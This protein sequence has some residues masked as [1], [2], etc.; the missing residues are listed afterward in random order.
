M[1]TALNLRVTYVAAD[2]TLIATVMEGYV[3][4]KEYTANVFATM[5]VTSPELQGSISTSG[6]SCDTAFPCWNH[7]NSFYVGE[8]VVGNVTQASLGF[9]LWYRDSTQSP[10]N[11]GSVFFA[12]S[13][14]MELLDVTGWF[15][16]SSHPSAISSLKRPC[17]APAR[18]MVQQDVGYSRRLS[19][20][21][22]T[23]PEEQ[24]LHVSIA[25]LRSHV[26][27]TAAQLS[28]YN[29]L[30]FEPLI[31]DLTS[32]EH[33]TIFASMDS[34]SAV[35]QE[36]TNQI[37][38]NDPG[39]PA[40]LVQLTTSLK[41]FALAISTP[42]IVYSTNRQHAKQLI[43]QLIQKKAD[44]A[45][46]VKQ[47]QHEF[48]DL[49]LDAYLK[50][51]VSSLRLFP[52]LIEDIIGHTR[53]TAPEKVD[54]VECRQD[55][56]KLIDRVH[57]EAKKMD[58]LAQLTHYEQLLLP[59]GDATKLPFNL[60]MPGRSFVQERQASINFA[61]RTLLRGKKQSKPIDA[62]LIL[63][64]DMLL[65]T[66][67]TKDSGTSK[68]SVISHKG[69][70]LFLT[71][72]KVDTVTQSPTV[73][74]A[75]KHDTFII[76]AKSPQEKKMWVS[77]LTPKPLRA[78][79]I[80]TSDAAAV[81]SA[82]DPFRS[83]QRRV[84][85]SMGSGPGFT[86][87]QDMTAHILSVSELAA[88]AHLRDLDRIVSVDNIPCTFL[89]NDGIMELVLRH[90]RT[91]TLVVSSSLQ[92]VVLLKEPDAGFG[93]TLSGSHPTFLQRLSRGTA[94]EKAG[95][96]VGDQLISVA[97]Q[98]VYHLPHA[99]LVK[100]LQE[101][102]SQG[103]VE[104]V[105]RPCL[106]HLSIARRPDGFGFRLTQGGDAPCQV[107]L[108]IPGSAS[109][110]SGLALGDQIWSVNG[111]TVRR[112]PLQRVQQLVARAKKQ[113][114]LV[115]ISTTK[116]VDLISE[117]HTVDCFGIHLEGSAPC[118]VQS[119]RRGSPAATAGLKAGD[120]I[121]EINGRAAIDLTTH[122]VL[123]LLQENTHH[124]RLRVTL[125]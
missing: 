116:Q 3:G 39:D 63:F 20:V 120:P 121:W 83:T 62:T 33:S 2:S 29:E 50:L 115:V 14:T 51:P 55:L 58:N 42:I 19:Q 105:V 18:G 82:I 125:S 118:R 31:Y 21:A 101:K 12:V 93:F 124:C 8:N 103:G 61:R 30:Y 112:M 73:H 88:E 68:Y 54:L 25:N 17:A 57:S 32:D 13:E 36:L 53:D 92:R 123:Q 74:V 87:R 64:S 35:F 113:I 97:G 7:T 23:D 48:P 5:Q 6:T 22:L 10:I 91:V 70:P 102:A 46:F 98:S 79:G 11:L 27:T 109:Q 44:F 38:E 106:R 28:D 99:N 47:Q 72:L 90:K 95:L 41:V 45:Q 66:T 107:S 80:K 100:L 59:I 81:K 69:L 111:K 37:S 85:L 84:T 52:S 56:A 117:P 78:N 9:T 60:V 43:S 24:C 76:N 114:N 122:A 96:R 77:L 104:F 108:I 49:T 71:D 40:A 16:L 4:V 89:T 26:V 34:V 86:L 110:A 15:E 119:V 94:A 75:G 1:T 67:L 65:L